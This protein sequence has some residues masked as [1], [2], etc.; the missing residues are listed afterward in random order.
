M[1]L[2]F[3]SAHLPASTLVGSKRPSSWALI[4]GKNLCCV[5]SLRLLVSHTTAQLNEDNLPLASWQAISHAKRRG[6][7]GHLAR[8]RG[9][10]G[11]FSRTVA[12]DFD[13]DFLC[14]LTEEAGPSKPPSPQC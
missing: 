14:S 11:A 8:L 3:H 9:R 4:V 10:R 13:T 2:S 7:R 12:M 6:G 5:T 1:D